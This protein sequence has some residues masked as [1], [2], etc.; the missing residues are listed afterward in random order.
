MR[1]IFSA[2][3]ALGLVAVTAHDRLDNRAQ[4]AGMAPSPTD[5]AG[6]QEGWAE[7]LFPEGLSHDFGT[8]PRGAQS[9][10]QFKMK[11]IFSEPLE[12]TLRISCGC[13]TAK[14]SVQVLEPL[15][16]G[17][18]DVLMD[19]KKYQ[20]PKTVTIEVTVGP[21]YV[22]QARLTVSGNCRMDVVLNPG[23]LFFG[24]ITPG[25]LVGPQALDVEYAGNADW[26]ITG[27]DKQNA[28]LDV[29]Y[30]QLYRRPGGVGY[31]VNATLKNVKPGP[32]KYEIFLKTNDP[33]SPLVPILV[34]GTVRDLLT[35]TP[36]PL[37]VGN[38]KV[39]ESVEKLILVKAGG[40]PFR[41]LSVD[42]LG[43]E[44]VAAI[45]TK[46]M[47]VVVLKVKYQPSKA[48]RFHKDLVIKTDLDKE[49][50]IKVTVDGAA[51]Q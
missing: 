28:P 46:A 38:L 21:K 14:P 11:N 51:E 8:V 2:L 24:N 27:L 5:P 12:L 40:A 44:I 26:R 50:Q 35:A 10:H 9:F 47:P 37:D 32:F 41:V 1:Y 34:E 45:P 15:H 19:A 31:H 48:G 42:G 39:G 7:K 6:P 16:E 33:T 23:Q 43:D 13:V 36:N 18:I 3:F 17:T 4:A 20:G 29:S 49:P 22:S 30:E 25:Q